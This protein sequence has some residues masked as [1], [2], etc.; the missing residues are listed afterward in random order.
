LDPAL[1]I[2]ELAATAEQD[3]I[4]TGNSFF[5][6][7]MR[8]RLDR[9][10]AKLRALS[11]ADLWQGR[12]GESLIEELYRGQAAITRLAAGD[13]DGWLARR[14][15]TA[16]HF[17]GIAEEIDTATMPDLARLLLA[18]QALGALAAAGE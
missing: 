17:L 4:V 6:V 16:D 5:A 12:A 1:A 15:R 18:S 10:V 2:V 8:L 11:G 14:R 7:G 13:L 3:P 9:M